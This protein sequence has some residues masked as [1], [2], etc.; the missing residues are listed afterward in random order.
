MNKPMTSLTRRTATAL[1]AAL[2]LSAGIAL[3]ATPAA[4]KVK[5][6]TVLGALSG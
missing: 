4:P 2:S 1:L 6:A 3:A 5:F